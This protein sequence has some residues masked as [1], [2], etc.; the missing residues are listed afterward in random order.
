[1]PAAAPLLPHRRVL[2][3]ADRRHRPVA[4]DADVAAD[5]LADV[6]HAAFFD[7]PWQERIGDRRPGGPDQVEHPLA[8]QAHHRVGRRQPADADD[9]LRREGFQA[10]EVPLL[11]RLAAEARGERVV[12]P[13]ADHHVPDVGQLA[14]QREQLL[15]L[16]ALDAFG[17]DQLVHDDPAGDGGPAVDLG[18]RV[19]EHLA[20][21]P[22][23][24]GE[25]AAVL[26]VAVVVAP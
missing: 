2:G 16:A 3:T 6:L 12:L 14:D 4:G 15:D 9:R 13:H 24:V 25:A 11:P 18:E 26:V 23:A 10:A 22:R 1:M 8:N 21:E 7:L 20:Q 17:A 5:A 19:L